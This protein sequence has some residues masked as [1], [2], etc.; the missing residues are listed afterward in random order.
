[1]CLATAALTVAP[2]TASSAEATASET[3][4]VVA[5][6]LNGSTATGTVVRG[7]LGQRLAVL[8][9]LSTEDLIPR[10]HPIRRIP[11]GRRGLTP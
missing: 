3:A 10:D 7:K 2:V 5:P 11:R 4:G 9:S 1:M 6:P 8:T